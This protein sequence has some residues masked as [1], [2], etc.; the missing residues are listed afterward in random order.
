MKDIREVFPSILLKDSLAIP[1]GLPDLLHLL[2]EYEVLSYPPG[3]PICSILVP[4][5]L[6]SISFGVVV[7]LKKVEHLDALLDVE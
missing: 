6:C 3:I 5:S 7:T 2:D 1:Q 4:K